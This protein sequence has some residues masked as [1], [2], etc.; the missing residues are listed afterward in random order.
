[1]DLL[2]GLERIQQD[3]DNGLF[4][5]QYAFEVTLQNLIYSAHDTHVNLV[6]GILGAFTFLSPHGIVSASIDGVQIPKV[7]ISGKTLKSF[8]IYDEADLS[9]T[10]L[11]GSTGA[12]SLLQF[13]LSTAR[14]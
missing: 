1:M 14:T 6:S 9:E 10:T 2:Q 3:I 8:S 11:V 5:T 13:Q 4:S 7:Y 12:G